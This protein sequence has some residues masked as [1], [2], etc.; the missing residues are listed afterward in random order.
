MS[1]N[2]NRANW[3]LLWTRSKSLVIFPIVI[4]YIFLNLVGPQS[5]GT[6]EK[7]RFG[8]MQAMSDQTTFKINDYIWSVDWARTPDGN[9]YS[10]KAPGIAFITFPVFYLVDQTVKLFTGKKIIER[11]TAGWIRILIATIYQLIPFAIIVLVLAWYFR[12]HESMPNSALV[13][14]ALATLFGNTASLFMINFMGHGFSAI[15][16][17]LL[18]ISLFYR[19]YFFTGLIFGQLFLGEYASIFILPVVIFTILYQNKKNFNWLI[20]FIT[21]GIVPGLLWCWYH[22]SC[23]GSI[24]KT[25]G[26]YQNP[27]F[28]DMANVKGNF[29]GIFAPYPK[30]QALFELL[31]GMKK[32]LLV[33]QPWILFLLII[34]PIKL[35]MNRQKLSAIKIEMVV[36]ILLSFLSLLLMNASFGAWHA[37]S[38]SGPRYLSMVLPMFGVVYLILNPTFLKSEKFILWSLLI[39][40]LVFKWLTYVTTVM[41]PPLD[42]WPYLLECAVTGYSKTILR[43]L[44][45]I[46]ASA[47]TFYWA[48]RL[49][50]QKRRLKN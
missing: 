40:A 37:G 6:N 36:F 30:P 50:I 5:A 29:L 31:F 27:D 48:K 21:G 11:A 46:F 20:P 17:T 47:G 28:V 23:Y 43:S 42:I 3:K 34:A 25:A 49:A 38:T 19:N 12:N 24:F 9:Y 39:I 22:Y 16:F 2:V 14:F 33:T 10:N 18:V 35:M 32:G 13:F 8:L 26:N 45:V 7:S 41:A 4:S 44:I 1:I 15:L